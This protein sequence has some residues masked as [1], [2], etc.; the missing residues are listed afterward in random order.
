M[1]D[2][3]DRERLASLA[4]ELVEVPSPTGDTAE[5]ARLYGRRL[6]ESGL[7]VELLD[8]AFSAT[9]IVVGR[10]RGGKPGPT[11]VLNGHL[12]T[13]PIPHEPPRLEGDVLVGRGAADMKGALA[14]AAE[15][16]RVLAASDRSFPGEVVI[17]AIGLHEAPT[18]RGEDLS[19]LL[20]ETG[21]T[22]DL[23]IVCE[24]GGHAFPVAHMGQATVELTISRP[25]MA[26]HELQ[27][28]PGTPHPLF[29]A[30]RVIEALAALRAELAATEHEWVGAE[31]IFLGE[32]H[33]GDFY[34]RHP[35]SCR[36]VGTRRWAPGRPFD[37]IEAEL[38]ALLAPLAEETGCEIELDCR[39][40]RDA[41][42]IDP[43]HELAL[44]L[45][46]AY[47]DVTG[48]ELPLV[49]LKVVA[50]GAIFHQAGIPTVYHGPVG[51]G[52]H[53]DVESI[54]V[55][56]LERAAKVYLRTLEWLWT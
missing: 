3:V 16:A 33:G 38:R 46:H 50:D 8:E 56:E 31:T 4:L 13:V 17:V 7:E 6:A 19:Y 22:A 24:L 37:D 2:R 15:A 51:S 27:T 43:E 26:T 25:G 42:R 14:S 35:T 11:V 39:L 28:P 9:P 40:V 36:I 5:V 41:Y 18:G 12:D 20:G 53:A 34:N 10:L 32:V 49:G 47:R 29:A 44:A 30:G 48:D 45:R 55:S 21:F 52:A 54:T 23:A 1:V